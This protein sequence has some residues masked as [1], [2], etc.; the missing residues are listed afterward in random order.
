MPASIAPALTCVVALFVAGLLLSDAKGARKK[1]FAFKTA[2]SLSFVLLALAVGALRAG[3]FGGFV[4][5]GLVLAA[6]GDVA[7]AVPG[8]RAFL[9]G[10]VLF[11]LGHVAYVVAC[12]SVTSVASWPSLYAGIPVVA[13]A[14]SYRML[15]SRLGSMRGPVIAYMLTIT[16]MVIGAIAVTRSGHFRGNTLL[17]GAV[18]FYLSDLSVARDR[19]VKHAF[20]NRAWGLPAY[21]AGQVLMAFAAG[22]AA[23]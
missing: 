13:T 18:L 5:A 2:A 1:K 23:S 11:L 3:A 10:L 17:P 9:V 21:Y 4:F 20:V 15:A 19:F 16:V 14:L 7:L 12:A 6:G 22:A 8:K